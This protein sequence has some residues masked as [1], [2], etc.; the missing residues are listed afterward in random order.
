MYELRVLALQLA[1]G[2][3][4]ASGSTS[5]MEANP[6]VDMAHRFLVFMEEANETET[7]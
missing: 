7:D 5:A 3:A 2:V 4:T 6:I 1:V